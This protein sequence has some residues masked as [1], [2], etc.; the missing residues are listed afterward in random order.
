MNV[1]SRAVPTLAFMLLAALTTAC[2]VEA[3]TN[4]AAPVVANT[5]VVP[6][7]D[8]DEPSTTTTEPEAS[9]TTTKPAAT[10]TT[11]PAAPT[12]APTT[13]DPGIGDLPPEYQDQ[14]LKGMI[15]A[16]VE[17][18][19]TQEQAQCLADTYGKDILNGADVDLSDA[20]GMLKYF[21]DCGVDPTQL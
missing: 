1:T 14:V 12:T 11:K 8:V 10:T 2:G 5:V 20:N 6:T 21:T 17:S 19:L 4:D 9:T 15:E 7:T 3:A 18:G 16:F 13:I